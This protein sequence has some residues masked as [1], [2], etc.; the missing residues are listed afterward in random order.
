MFTSDTRGNDWR[1]SLKSVFEVWYMYYILDVEPY[2][3]SCVVELCSIYS[4]TY[5]G[6]MDLQKL[7][8]IHYILWYIVMVYYKYIVWYFPYFVIYCINILYMLYIQC[9]MSR[10]SIQCVFAIVCMWGCADGEQ[11]IIGSLKHNSITLFLH[12]NRNTRKQLKVHNSLC[13]CVCVCQKHR[14]N[15]N[16]PVGLVHHGN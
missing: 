8:Y 12:L 7:W 16:R 6:L 2:S 3:H 1:K 5:S 10:S 11:M 4:L 14:W 13:I 9:K 15:V